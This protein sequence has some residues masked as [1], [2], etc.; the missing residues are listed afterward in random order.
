MKYSKT[1]NEVYDNLNNGFIYATWQE[2][3]R[4]PGYWAVMWKVTGNNFK[5]YIYWNNYGSSHEPFTKH[6]VK[7]LI[8]EIFRTTPEQFTKKYECVSEYDYYHAIHNGKDYSKVDNGYKAAFY[9]MGE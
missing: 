1:I 3:L 4:F 2:D 5:P 7:W 9:N 8:E 6:Y